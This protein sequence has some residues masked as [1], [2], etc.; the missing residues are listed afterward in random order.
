MYT[1]VVYIIFER[2]KT[3]SRNETRTRERLL[4]RFHVSPGRVPHSQQGL[5]RCLLIAQ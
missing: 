1:T 5:T 4:W 2:G 3:A